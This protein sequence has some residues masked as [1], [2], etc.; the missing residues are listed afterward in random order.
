MIRKIIV[1][2]EEYTSDEN[3][4]IRFGQGH[5]QIY[6]KETKQ[7]LLISTENKNVTTISDGIKPKTN[8]RYKYYLKGKAA[9]IKGN[10]IIIRKKENNF[11]V[12]E[13]I[14]I[15]RMQLDYQ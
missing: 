2:N 1:D 11:N 5:V 3:T 9:N 6:N 10:Y 7:V 4:E 8:R 13:A 14:P 15:K 12:T